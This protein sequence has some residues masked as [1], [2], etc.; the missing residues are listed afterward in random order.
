MSHFINKFCTFLQHDQSLKI[1][2]PSDHSGGSINCTSFVFWSSNIHSLV[3]QITEMKSLTI[4]VWEFGYFH[5]LQESTKTQSSTTNLYLN[6]SMHRAHRC[7]KVCKS[8]KKGQWRCGI[9]RWHYLPSS[10]HQR[11]KGWEWRRITILTSA[12]L[13]QQTRTWSE[14]NR[15]LFFLAAS[16]LNLHLP[17]FFSQNTLHTSIGMV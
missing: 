2:L 13:A 10:P 7:K 16:V 9:Y 12:F 8:L 17:E 14:Q 6:P 5:T 11:T 1:W 3:Q 4:T 15:K